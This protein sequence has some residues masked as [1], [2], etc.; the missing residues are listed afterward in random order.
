MRDAY[1]DSGNLDIRLGFL[2][3]RQVGDEA[4]DYKGD[5]STPCDKPYADRHQ[6]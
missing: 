3:D 6:R 2:R 4:A 1:V 5:A